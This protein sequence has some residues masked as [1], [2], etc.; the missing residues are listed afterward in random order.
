MTFSSVKDRARKLICTWITA[1]FAYAAITLGSM[2]ACVQQPGPAAAHAAHGHSSHGMHSS[3]LPAANQCSV[4]LCCIQ[5][6]GAPSEPGSSGHVTS[7]QQAS[8]PTATGFVLLRPSHTLP[9]AQGPPHS[10][11]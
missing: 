8:G 6:S 4:H 3:G 5:L 2:P 10:P 11:V 9:F 1:C 7:S